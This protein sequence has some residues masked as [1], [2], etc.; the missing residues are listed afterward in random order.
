MKKVDNFLAN[1]L[2]CLLIGL[3]LADGADAHPCLPCNTITQEDG[4]TIRNI[5]ISGPYFYAKGVPQELQK[6]VENIVGIGKLYSP[7]NL[8]SAIREINNTLGNDQENDAKRNIFYVSYVTADTCDVSDRA[9][10]KQ[11]EVTISV[12][13]VTVPDWIIEEIQNNKTI[14]TKELVNVQAK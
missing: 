2:C 11:V 13:R 8:S 1:F 6:R 3:P 9:N 4:F 5:I 10:P 7:E 12:L 14:K